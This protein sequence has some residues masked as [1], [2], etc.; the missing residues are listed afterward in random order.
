LGINSKVIF[1]FVWQ[2]FEKGVFE[3]VSKQCRDLEETI[4][5]RNLQAKETTEDCTSTDSSK[6]CSSTNLHDTNTSAQDLKD[7]S[8]DENESSD[9]D[10]N[11]SDI[12]EDEEEKMMNFDSILKVKKDG[13]SSTDEVKPQTES[14]E[15]NMDIDQ[16]KDL[17]PGDDCN[18]SDEDEK[19]SE[20][21]TNKP[22]EPDDRTISSVE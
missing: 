16:D 21:Q 17:K 15:I 10:D 3:E 7:V 20:D 12:F 13:S 14:M 4:R 18:P 8:K 1:S 2:D 19:V 5:K 6:E 11:E 22:S 9:N